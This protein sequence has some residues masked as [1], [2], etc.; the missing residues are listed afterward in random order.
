MRRYYR[1]VLFLVIRRIFYSIIGVIL[2]IKYTTIGCKI[3]KG[4]RVI[5]SFKIRGWSMN[6][7]IG[8]NVDI[9]NNCCLLVGRYGLIKI[10]NRSSVSYN[11]IVNAGD[12]KIKIGEN[13]MIAGNCY[14]VANDHD[15][16]STLSV[17]DSG[18]ITKDINIGD[19][20]WIGANVVITKGVC[21]GNGSIIGA[22]A[23]VTKSIPEMSIA[24]GV[25]CKVISQRKLHNYGYREQ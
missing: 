14:I 18:H 3:G 25:P 12:G 11:T 4:L 16:F 2:R 15:I 9:H 19:N 24:V 20:V 5:G 10:G 23:V 22:G 13:T 6:I 7:D 21:I 17:R 1:T 8:N